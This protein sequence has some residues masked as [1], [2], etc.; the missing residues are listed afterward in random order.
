MTQDVFL[1]HHGKEKPKFLTWQIPVGTPPWNRDF[2]TMYIELFGSQIRLVKGKKYTTRVIEAG[3]GEPLILIHGVG[4]QAEAFYRNIISLAKD[5]HVCAI[6]ALYHG[7]SSKESD[8]IDSTAAQVD[9]VLDFMD[10]MGFDSAHFEG[11]SMGS[12]ITFRLALEHPDRVKRIVLNTGHQVKI[13]RTDFRQPLKSADSLQVLTLAAAGAPDAQ[14]V[15]LRMEWLMATPDRVIDELVALRLKA[16]QFP[17]ARPNME[18]MRIGGGPNNRWFEEEECQ[19]IKAETL[20]FW[21]E[22]NPGFG[23]DVGEYLAS[24][25][26]GAKFYCMPDAAH[27]PQYEHPE[28]HD[29][30]IT[31]FFKTGQV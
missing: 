11:E 1:S 4:G 3:E 21:T 5:F 7:F 22:F 30:V 18:A 19:G 25:I 29:A 2:G 28:E 10:A 27:W 14:N 16:Y 23:P 17:D 15:R 6:D 13:R 20:V 8:I 26:P 12:N 24:L 31:K 9:H